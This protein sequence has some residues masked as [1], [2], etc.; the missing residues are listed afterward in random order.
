MEKVSHKYAVLLE[1]EGEMLKKATNIQMLLSEKFNIKYILDSSPRSHIT[2][3]SGFTIN[4]FARFK[5]NLISLCKK[6][7]RFSLQTKGLGIFL[8][9]KPVIYIRWSNNIELLSLKNQLHE[10]LKRSAT[11]NI[12]ENYSIDLDWLPKTTLAYGD[13]KYENLSSVIKTIRELDFIESTKISSISIYS[14]VPGGKETSQTCIPL[15]KSCT[16][17]GDY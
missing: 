9:E 3:E 8:T 7:T 2:L 16:N 10:L 4:N 17:R 13:T 11:K 1:I 6:I 5:K 15:K 12:V 14:Y